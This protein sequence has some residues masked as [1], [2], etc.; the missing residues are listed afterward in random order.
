MRKIGP[1]RPFREIAD[2]YKMNPSI[3]ELRYKINP[4]VGD[5]NRWDLIIRKAQIFKPFNSKD[6]GIANHKDY[7]PGH[8]N[9]DKYHLAD[10]GI[11]EWSLDMRVPLTDGDDLGFISE[12]VTWA[13]KG[14]A[15][16]VDGNTG[17]CGMSFSGALIVGSVIPKLPGVPAC[18]WRSKRKPTGRRRMIEG[19]RPR[20]VILID[21]LIGR[22]NAKFRAIKDLKQAGINVTGILCVI[23]YG[24]R[25]GFEK[26]S[27]VVKCASLVDL[28]E[29]IA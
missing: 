8:P 5:K 27:K 18:I 3:P 7:L 11:A 17:I 4:N 23:R 15:F 25:D 21:D 12:H 19:A 20:D 14:G 6:F 16:H 28:G 9:F 13:L 29:R 22:G 1:K 24:H 10:G 26:L 2:K